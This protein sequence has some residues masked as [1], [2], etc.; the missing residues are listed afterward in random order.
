MKSMALVMCLT[1]I[2]CGDVE[3]DERTAPASDDGAMF[4][5]QVEVFSEAVLPAPPLAGPVHVLSGTKPV[6]VVYVNFD[7]PTV[8]DCNCSDSKTNQSLVIGHIFGAN[9]VNFAPY[10]NTS[11]QSAIVA[12]LRGYFADYNIAFTTTRPTSGD[13]TMMI[14]SPTSGPHHGVAPQD[15]DN[16]NRN[17]IAFVYKIGSSSVDTISR[18]AAHELGHSFGLAHVKESTDIMQWASA[19]SAFRRSTLDKSDAHWFGACVE[20]NVQ[21]EP[22]MLAGTLGP[23][24]PPEPETWNGTFQDDDAS[25]F[26]ESIEKIA[27]AGITAGCGQSPPRYC[28][29]DTVTRGQMAAFLTRA[30]RLPAASTDYFSDDAGSIFEDSINRL[31]EAGI[32][33]GCATGRYCPTGT[34]TRGQMAVFLSRALDLPASSVDRFDDDA[35]K[36]YEESANRMYDAQ[37]TVGCGARKYCGEDD[38]TRG[39]MAAFLTRALDL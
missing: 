7:G 35:G 18:F 32:T 11:A 23:K 5:G 2:G 38:V 4:V 9:S 21:D 6:Q 10:T 39:Q 17:D 15:C 24:A 22:V 3:L 37:I 27:A 1:L 16:R 26:E 30:L 28:P 34:V 12:K 14:I 19:G 33:S 29:D 13:Y 31:A 8:T 36:F 20:G 25:I